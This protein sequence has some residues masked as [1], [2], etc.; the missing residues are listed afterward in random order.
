M[1]S[2]HIKNL[3]RNLSKLYNIKTKNNLIIP[4]CFEYYS[5]IMLTKTYDTPFNVWKDVSN[6]QKKEYNFPIRDKGID[7]VNEKFSIIGQSKYYKKSSLTYEKLST[8]LAI[9]KIVDKKDF[10]MVLVRLSDSKIDKHIKEMISKGILIDFQIDEK[11][12]L[13]KCKEFE[14]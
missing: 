13:N 12:F 1:I 7:L 10:Q 2:N 11:D 8:F 3:E 9:D 6:Q 14:E 5:A 4:T